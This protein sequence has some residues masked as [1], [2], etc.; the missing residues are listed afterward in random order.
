MNVYQKLPLC[1]VKRKPL[2]TAILMFLV[3]LLAFTAFGGVLITYSLQNGMLSLNNRLGADIMVV[4]DEAAERKDLQNIVLQ[5]NKG[6]FYMDKSKLDEVCALEG[7]EEIS[8]QVFLCSASAGCC[9][10]AV[11]IMGFDPDTDFCIRPWIEDDTNVKLNEYD[12]VIGSDLSADVGESIRFYDVSCNVV[13]KLK[14]TGTHYDTCAFANNDTLKILINGS[15]GKGLNTYKEINPDKVISCIM[16]NV[17]DGYSIDDLVNDI[18]LRINGVTAVRTA[19]MISGVSSGLVGISKTISVL[20]IAIWILAFIIMFLAFSM[21]LNERK[22]EFAVLRVIGVS[23]KK[24]T[25]SVWKEILLI[26]VCGGFAGV[27]LG[28]IVVVP[29][30]DLIRQQLDMPMLLPNGDKI[31]LYLVSALVGSIAAGSFA[32]LFAVH[33]IS[34][35]DAGL[36]L[37][38]GQ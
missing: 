8:P 32:S 18:N 11:Q 12:I 17:Q 5:G 2:K 29:F 28:F 22:K 3:A 7:I 16:I 4:P 10:V 15:L 20:I 26:C 1:N 38:E 24:L 23:R 21:T 35:I 19:T 25:T 9:S 33:R 34:R 31:V 27:I 37:R 13:G 14:K 6:Y 30:S 36:I